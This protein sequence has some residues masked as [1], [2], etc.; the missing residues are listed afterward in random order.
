MY[1]PYRGQP[2][3]L[4]YT[5]KLILDVKDFAEYKFGENLLTQILPHYDRPDI[6]YC[7]DET[8]K[9]ITSQLVDCFQ[10][11]DVHTGNIY[12]KEFVLSQKPELAAQIDK[13]RL[14]AIVVGGWNFYLRDTQKPTGSLK[15]K[16][17]QLRLI[18]YNPVLIF[19][20][21]WANRQLH[22]KEDIFMKK[23]NAAFSN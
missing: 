9:S 8:G 18:G 21:D 14:F 23:M 19:W 17:E 20:N 1:I 5:D 6:I 22:I 16:L 3:K 12:T 11:R 15:M 13:L 4:T 2:Y 7:L 10:P